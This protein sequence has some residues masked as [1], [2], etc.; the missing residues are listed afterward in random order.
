[1]KRLLGALALRQLITDQATGILSA[2]AAVALFA[3][4]TVIS[5]MGLTSTSLALPELAMLRF[6]VAGLILLPVL[7]RRGLGPLRWWQAASLAITG[8]LGFALFAYTG[9]RL[10]PASH[11]GVL[12][13]G[14]I[15][16]FT[17]VLAWW[18]TRSRPSIRGGLA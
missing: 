2:L 3:S 12:L 1:M 15:P 17:V 8:G 6:G 9:F 14:T 7:L 11:G 13:H 4:F 18:M 16:L 10:A 5:R